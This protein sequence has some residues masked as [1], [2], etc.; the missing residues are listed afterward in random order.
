MGLL[1]KLQTVIEDCH[2]EVTVSITVER[3]F[4]HCSAAREVFFSFYAI[5]SPLRVGCL[6]SRVGTVIIFN[7]A[8]EMLEIAP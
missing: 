5:V 3:I 6:Q 7:E 1:T 8:S 2:P 4:C